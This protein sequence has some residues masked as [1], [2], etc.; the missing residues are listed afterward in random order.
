MKNKKTIIIA[1]VAIISLLAWMFFHNND[2]KNGGVELDEERTE[3]ERTITSE[4][5]DSS[6]VKLRKLKQ[7]QIFVRDS[8]KTLIRDSLVPVHKFNR[9][10]IKL[11]NANRNQ[12]ISN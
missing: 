6:L 3:F 12:T 10:K 7:K 9:I 11:K 1:S 2:I 5:A 4:Q 8:L